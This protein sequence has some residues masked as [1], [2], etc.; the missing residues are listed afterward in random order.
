MSESLIKEHSLT[1]LE[2]IEKVNQNAQLEAVFMLPVLLV[3]SLETRQQ[4]VRMRIATVLK[5]VQSRGF[6]VAS[7][8]FGDI[9]MLWDI[10]KS[11]DAKTE[12]AISITPRQIP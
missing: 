2:S 7:T 8:Y 11:H 1:A 4:D 6:V 10:F 12:D 5:S 3:V 9:S